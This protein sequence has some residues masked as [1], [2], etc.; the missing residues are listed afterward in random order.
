MRPEAA[1]GEQHLGDL[2]EQQRDR[3]SVGRLAAGDRTQGDQEALDLVGDLLR[4]V[5]QVAVQTVARGRPLLTHRR[6]VSLRTPGRA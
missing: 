6:I 3:Q 4:E 5:L 2:E 1:A